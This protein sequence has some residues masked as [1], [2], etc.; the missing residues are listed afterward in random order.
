[1]LPL[2][3]HEV[4]VPND[5]MEPHPAKQLAVVA[6]QIKLPLFWPKDPALWFTQIKAQFTTCGITASWTK[7]DY[8][9][10]SLTRVRHRGQGPASESTQRTAI[11]GPQERAHK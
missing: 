8:V 1:M 3:D 5:V 9:V 2:M 11:R 6:V 4:P 10:S 7:F